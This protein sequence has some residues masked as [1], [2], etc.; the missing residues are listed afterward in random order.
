METAAPHVMNALGR[1]LAESRDLVLAEGEPGLRPSHHRVI[2]HVPAEGITVTE[3]AQRVGMTK[4]GIGQFVSQL[5]RSG[6][7]RITTDPD[8][9]RVR[10]VRRTAKGEASVQRLATLLGRLEQT[11]ASRVGPD[12]YREFRALLDQLAGS[13]G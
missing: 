4:Q 10:V 6:H 1:L 13:A 5:T 7:L 2:G 8:D 12:R 3:L 11:W 9:R